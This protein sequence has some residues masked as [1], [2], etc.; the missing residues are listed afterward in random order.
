MRL[1]QTI[2]NNKKVD[3]I[4]NCVPQILKPKQVLV[5]DIVSL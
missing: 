5:G 2:E 3:V 4:R 1:Q